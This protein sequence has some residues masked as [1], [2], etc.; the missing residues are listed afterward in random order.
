MGGKH[1]GKN[2]RHCIMVDD[3]PVDAVRLLLSLVYVGS[4]DGDES[5]WVLIAALELAHRWQIHY[6]VQM[7]VKAISSKLEVE[8]FEL[9]LETAI[10]LHLEDL[11]MACRTFARNS[12]VLQERARNCAA[13]PLLCAEMEK[14]L[15]GTGLVEHPPKRRRSIF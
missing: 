11:R 12:C 10:R 13:S 9:V 15:G 1:T 5:N 3:A 6:V 4:A 14:V 8:S 7:L 2:S